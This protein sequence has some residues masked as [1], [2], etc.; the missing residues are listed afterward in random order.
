MAQLIK[1]QD[2][3][4][5]YESDIYHYPAKYI[6]L[7]QEKWKKV[8]RNWENG[9][10]D[11]GSHPEQSTE[12]PDHKP[13]NWKQLFSRNKIKEEQWEE[14]VEEPWIPG[15]INELKKYFLD[16]L[17]PFQLKW[18]ST[19]LLEKSFIDPGIE[20]EKYLR[21]L[22]QRLPDHY[23][24]MYKPVVM[25]K[26]AAM[27]ADIIIIGPYHI[28][29][30]SC[31]DV[32][33]DFISPQSQNK[34]MIEKDGEQRT[35]FSP[36]LSLR[37]TETF[38]RSIMQTYEHPIDFKLTVLAYDL[39]I[40][41]SKEPYLTSYIDKHSFESWLA[42]KRKLGAPLKHGQLALAENLLK[43][44]RT[45]AVKRPEWEDDETAATDE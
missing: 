40:S 41:A 35:I 33:A 10:F 39:T 27:E 34:W 4:S 2:Y 37:R 25:L 12:L 30:V 8:K 9:Q 7:K 19:T 43:H 16:E 23:L 38:L 24:I 13:F 15:D 17:Y 42:E 32:E 44:T 29:L 22:L 11:G 5:R 28:E 21:M 36:L 6:R 31:I 26:K 20:N 45:I 18:A 3:I 14:P 1:L